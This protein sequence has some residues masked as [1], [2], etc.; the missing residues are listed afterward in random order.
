MHPQKRGDHSSI[1]SLFSDMKPYKTLQQTSMVHWSQQQHRLSGAI[2]DH[3]G[4]QDYG[5]PI[6]Q[7]IQGASFTIA[8]SQRTSS[9]GKLDIGTGHMS[10]QWTQVADL[11]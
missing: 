4:L 11:D 10:R 2:A 5:R 3:L 6:L 7:E 8:L 1:H 9:A